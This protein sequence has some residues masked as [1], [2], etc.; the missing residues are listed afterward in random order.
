M[1]KI[2]ILLSVLF[3]LYLYIRN[4]INLFYIQAFWRSKNRH[5][6]TA[7]AN[8]VTDIPFPIDR[9]SVG[10]F[11]YGPLRVISHNPFASGIQIGDFCS[12]SSGVI[13][14][15]AGDH[16]YQSL[17]TYPFLNNFCDKKESK[18]KGPTIVADDVWI[19]TDALILSGVNIGKGAIIAARSVVTHDVPPYSIVAGVPA[20]VVKYRF[21]PD[22]IERVK[23]INLKKIDKDF[24]IQN[25]DLLTNNITDKEITTLE[26]LIN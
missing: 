2:R 18:S 1:H 11:T 9:V 25:I 20:R 5:N 24:I 17:T 21:S 19:G 14:L 4:T 6:S 10:R 16:E 23:N 3:R 22:T 26:S 13:F 15:I 7:V 8:F 12:I